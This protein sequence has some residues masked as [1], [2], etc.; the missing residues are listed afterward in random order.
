[1]IQNTLQRAAPV[2]RQPPVADTVM[3]RDGRPPLMSR[4]RPVLAAEALEDHDRRPRPP[5]EHVAGADLPKPLTGAASPARRWRCSRAAPKTE[6]WLMI[7]QQKTENLVEI[8]LH[9]QLQAVL[10]AIRA[11]SAGRRRQEGH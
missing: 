1:M 9:A 6:S 7:R 5:E 3:P 4:W 2:A 11:T 8:P 10:A